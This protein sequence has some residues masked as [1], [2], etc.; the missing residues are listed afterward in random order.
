MPVHIVFDLNDTQTIEAIP[1]DIRFN[2]I[3]FAEVIEHLHTAPE[4]VL[5]ALCNLLTDDGIIVC[6]TPNALGAAQTHHP[7]AR[8]RNPY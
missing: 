3:V 1:T 6:Q 5:H 8:A 4:L 7:A 2:L